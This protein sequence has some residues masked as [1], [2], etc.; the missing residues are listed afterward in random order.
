MLITTV[1]KEK[2]TVWTS[3]SKNEVKVIAYFI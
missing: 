1:L 2:E 3:V